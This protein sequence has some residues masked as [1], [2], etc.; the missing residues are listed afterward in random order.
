MLNKEDRIIDLFH[1]SF[2]AESYL[3]RGMPCIFKCEHQSECEV[4]I[5]NEPIW[6]PAFGDNGTKV[7][8]VAEAP[9]STGGKGPHIGGYIKD[10]EKENET[11][12]NSLFRYVRKF[13]NTIP[14]FTDL[15]KC[16]ISR[17]ST[18]KK[19]KVFNKRTKYCADKF[20]I[21]E[22]EIITPEVILCVGKRAF[23]A[24][25]NYKDKY[26]YELIQLIHYGRQANL[27]LTSED[28][29]NI[30]WPLQSNKISKD[31]IGKNISKLSFI[32][33]LSP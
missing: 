11:T 30:I 28:K 17:Q 24:L 18:E 21:K 33:K 23:D 9:S 13:Y 3:K 12:V 1:D 22:I 10:W 2:K 14:Y 19:N 27:P 8:I 32:R 4:D 5:K 15:M 20:L 29:E 7:M 25:N 26:N 31:E 16:G 6:M